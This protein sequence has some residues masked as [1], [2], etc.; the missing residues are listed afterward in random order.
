M[1]VVIPSVNGWPDLERCLT[2]LEAEAT[3]VSLEILIPERCGTA[4]REAV[5]ARFP[6]ATVLP[7]TPDTTIPQMRAAGM[8]AA[9]APSV[10]VI[11][12]HV[13]VSRGWAAA[14]LAAR[15]DTAQ[16]VGGHLVNTATDTVVDWAA[17]LCEYHHLAN[18]MP[19]G[20]VPGLHGNHTVY[21]ATLLH[22]FRH[23]VAT[24]QWEDALHKAFQ[25]E[26]ISLWS[27][28]DIVAGHC[29]H[30]TVKEY[31]TQR[32]F[33]SRA[34]AAMRARTMSPASKVAYGAVAAALPPVL[35]LRIIRQ[36]RASESYRPYLTRSLPLLLL[37]VCSWA[38][39]E[40]V[41]A[42]FGDGGALAK[43]A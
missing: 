31:T 24:G 9:R 5:H 43:V 1:S 39:G 11:E 38:V 10:A 3:S 19:A 34:Y 41:G 22:R 20:S 14:M 15:T 16:V 23:V 21:D 12:D 4:V 40:M 29:K 33:Y 27:R 6:W 8:M 30:Y 36:V 26:G 18:P 13:L 32:Y 17:W 28:P 37:F 35:L 7:V 25:V 2:A 42:W